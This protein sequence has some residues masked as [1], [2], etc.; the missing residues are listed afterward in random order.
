[1][2]RILPVERFIYLQPVGRGKTEVLD[3]QILQRLCADLTKQ[4]GIGC[5]AL[6]SI[7]LT[8]DSYDPQR[9]QY[10]AEI[11]LSNLKRLGF[12]EAEKVLGI[13]AEDLYAEGLNFVFG[14]AELGGKYSVVSVSRLRSSPDEKD[15]DLFYERILKECVHELGHTFG[16]GHCPNVRCVMHFSNTLRDTDIKAASFCN[17]CQ[18]WL[19]THLKKAAN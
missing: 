4:F 1:M 17:Y 10:L 18:S 15:E 19:G 7:N 14:Q 11:I 3:Q 9:D 2:F 16:L 12:S 13:V 6:P 8:E 5:R